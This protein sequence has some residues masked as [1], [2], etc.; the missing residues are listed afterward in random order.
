MMV[1]VVVREVVA[2]HMGVT[3]IGTGSWSG[4][5]VVVF[6]ENKDGSG[7]TRMPVVDKKARGVFVVAS[8]MTR[9]GWGGEVSLTEKLPYSRIG[10]MGM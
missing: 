3:S 10:S 1:V 9:S 7:P 4:V 2:I 5:T 6:G 8:D